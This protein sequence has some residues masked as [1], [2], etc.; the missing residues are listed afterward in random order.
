MK[1][2]CDCIFEVSAGCPI[3][4]ASGMSAGKAANH[5]HMTVECCDD[6][7]CG[8]PRPRSQSHDHKGSVAA[9]TL[10]TDHNSYFFSA[11]V[12]LNRH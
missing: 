9:K 7:K 2:S 4:F 11:I 1:S 10:R 6:W 5:D 8:L 3:D 12:T